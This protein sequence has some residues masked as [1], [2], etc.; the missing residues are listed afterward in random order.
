MLYFSAYFA[1]GCWVFSLRQL[2]A[3]A[4]DNE[5]ADEVE[6]VVMGIADV[7]DV[8]KTSPRTFTM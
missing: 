1:D 7:V 3:E 6:V 8:D 4:C 5:L 2:N